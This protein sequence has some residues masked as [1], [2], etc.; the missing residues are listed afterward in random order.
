MRAAQDVVD[1]DGRSRLIILLR[2]Y[3]IAGILLDL[4]RADKD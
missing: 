3:F 4:L 1:E 2:R